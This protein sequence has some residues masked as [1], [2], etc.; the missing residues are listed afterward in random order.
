[1]TSVD[2]NKWR[3]EYC[4]KNISSTRQMLDIEALVSH[5]VNRHFCA[6]HVWFKTCCKLMLKLVAFYNRNFE[7]SLL[8]QMPKEPNLIEQMPFE[9]NV[10]EQMALRQ[11]LLVQMS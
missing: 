11:N 6:H 9:Q 3:H 1:M 8:K 7:Q 5:I 2:E 10:L 4:T